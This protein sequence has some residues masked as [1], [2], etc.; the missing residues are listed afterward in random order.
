MRIFRIKAGDTDNVKP[1]S[2][3]PFILAAKGTIYI[4]KVAPFIHDQRTKEWYPISPEEWRRRNFDA[5]RR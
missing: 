5:T 4:E 1:F 3:L 2:R